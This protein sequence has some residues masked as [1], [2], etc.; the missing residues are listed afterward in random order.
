MKCVD[1]ITEF[2]ADYID[3]RLPAETRA[4]FER[5]IAGCDSCT[6]YLQNY[7]ATI[8]MAAGAHR[9]PRFSEV[10]EELVAA[11]LKVVR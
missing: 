6:A 7:R 10:P 4:A 8:A 3:G 1:V 5:H 9:E 11:I 2:I